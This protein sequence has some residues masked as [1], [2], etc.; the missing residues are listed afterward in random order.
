VPA[1]LIQS[2]GPAEPGPIP[3]TRLGY[4]LNSRDDVFIDSATGQYFVLADGQ[5]YRSASLT[6][7]AGWKPVGPDLL[8]AD[9]ARIPPGSPKAGAREAVAGTPEQREAARQ[10]QV[11]QTM[12]VD[13][14]ATTEI[15]YDG[16]PRFSPIPG[17]HLSYA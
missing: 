1:I 14:L 8:P 11:P 7:S 16:V 3:G 2:D 9:F 10:A 4:I 6:N 13:R 12:K 15:D 5:W 17:T